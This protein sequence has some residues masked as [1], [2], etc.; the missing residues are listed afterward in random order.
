MKT[1]FHRYAI[2]LA[3]VASG[4]PAH[5]GF[6]FEKAPDPL[7]PLEVSAPKKPLNAPASAA[8]SSAR[9]VNPSAK[10]DSLAKRNR[11]RLDLES[12][13]TSRITQSGTPPTEL[14]VLR[15][16]GR[17]VMFEDALRMVLPAGWSAYSDQDI[18]EGTNVDWQ[19]NRTWPMVLH[20]ILSARDM[21]AH[22]DWSS[23]EVMFFVPAPPAAKPALVVA[24]A[25]DAA[26]A[27]E[28]V[29]DKATEKAVEPEKAAE[30]AKLPATG[31]AKTEKAT[32]AA[33]VAKVEVQPATWRLEKDKTLRENLR[34]WATQVGWN[35]VWNATV[36]DQV[37]DYPV[38]ETAVLQGDLIGPAGA[39][40][41]VMLLYEDAER[42]LA[43]EFYRGNRVVV[44]R[45]A[46]VQDVRGPEPGPASS[47]VKRSPVQK[48][49]PKP[50]V[51]APA[52]DASMAGG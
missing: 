17:D 13:V 4:L 18:P 1:N 3:L 47:H 37:V 43:I 32:E 21:R 8:P 41:K 28:K 6:L 51:K 19:G 42:P 25:E 38:E 27:A 7:P 26:S 11:Q 31:V 40:A 14:P 16:M 34:G 15:G 10:V 35:L 2:T 23:Q 36:G 48:P 29:A 30:P 20:S 44:V 33:A 45:L 46:Q 49:E 5:A 12:R 50:T 9:D 52:F 22:I 24:A 39:M